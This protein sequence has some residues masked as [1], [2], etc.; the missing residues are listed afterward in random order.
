[1]WQVLWRSSKVFPVEMAEVQLLWLHVPACTSVT[2]RQ[3]GTLG[4]GASIHGNTKGKSKQVYKGKKHSYIWLFFLQ[5]KSRFIENHLSYLVTYHSA[6]ISEQQKTS[7]CCGT[8]IKLHQTHSRS[9]W[10][11][12]RFGLTSLPWD[13]V[14]WGKAAYRCILQNINNTTNFNLFSCLFESIHTSRKM[15]L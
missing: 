14:E 7:I 11:R 4:V 13:K 12:N 9:W 5:R 2:Q 3:K 15:Y 1:M 10:V 8:S 6:G